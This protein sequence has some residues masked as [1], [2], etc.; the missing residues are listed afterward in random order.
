MF[1]FSFSFDH[2]VNHFV[3]LETKR[4][5]YDHITNLIISN[6]SQETHDLNFDRLSNYFYLFKKELA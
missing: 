4:N 5:A 6:I 3:G 2:L 1:F